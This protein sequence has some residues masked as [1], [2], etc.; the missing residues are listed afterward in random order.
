MNETTRGV[1]RTDTDRAG[2]RHGWKTKL[3]RETVYQPRMWPPEMQECEAC[4]GWYS[5]DA[6]DF[7]PPGFCC[8]TC[9]DTV[10]RLKRELAERAV[11]A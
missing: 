9:S 4:G 1:D 10:R 5:R 8:V 6:V 2:I 3:T 11:R 7:P